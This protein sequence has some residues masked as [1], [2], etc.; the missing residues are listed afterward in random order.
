MSSEDEQK[1]DQ[2]M[3]DKLATTFNNGTT[4]TSSSST[5]PPTETI[6]ELESDG[7]HVEDQDIVDPW[8][9]T[10]TNSTGIDYDKLIGKR[11]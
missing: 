9:V 6:N 11:V 5:L 3:I 2:Q 4:I 10:S 1:Q 7:D 8:N